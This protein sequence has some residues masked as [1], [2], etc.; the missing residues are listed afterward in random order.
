MGI[1][2]WFAR[3]K[4]GGQT[5]L[6]EMRNNGKMTLVLVGPFLFAWLFVQIFVPLEYADVGVFLLCIGE[7]AYCIFLYQWAKS[8]AAGYRAFPQ[9]PWRFPDGGVRTY[10]RILIAPDAVE[11][12]CDF[13][14]GSVGY[15]VFLGEKFQYQQKNAP[16]PYVFDMA[17]MK[18]PD[19]WDGAFAFA[20]GGEFFHKGIAVQHP[21]CESISVYVVGWNKNEDGGY[22]PVCLI[23]DCAFQYDRMMNNGKKIDKLEFEEADEFEMLY[24][25][26]QKRIMELIRHSSILET[27]LEVMSDQSKDFKKQVDTTL[28]GARKRVHLITDT[29]ESLFK[30]YFNFKNVM[31]AVLIVTLLL[32]VS[33]FFMG[34]P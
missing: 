8:D 2:D 1:R 19:E 7:V 21:A 13:E 29:K 32:L 20:S 24:K 26:A 18:V 10:D 3:R 9:P 15:R 14:D 11:K 16:F 17:F 23:N 6:S 4:Y 33:H 30:R 12:I 28:E 27:A 22:E 25:N 31:K 5:G 34:W